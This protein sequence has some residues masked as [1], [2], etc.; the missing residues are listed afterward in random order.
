[1]VQNVTWGVIISTRSLVLQRVA[2]YHAGQYSCSAANDRGETQSLPV[3]L[4]IHCEYSV[5]LPIIIYG[6][7]QQQ[8]H[9]LIGTVLWTSGVSRHIQLRMNSE[10]L[11][12]V[13]KSCFLN[14]TDDDPGDKQLSHMMEMV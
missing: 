6:Q 4:R 11:W 7:S 9:V 2:R 8:A 10:C 12:S 5:S 14:V 1:M 13:P 3:Q